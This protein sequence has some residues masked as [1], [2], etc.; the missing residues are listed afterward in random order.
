[1]DLSN[2]YQEVKSLPDDV[3]QR[4]MAQP[5]GMIPS[6]LIMG[7]LYD[8][9]A[10]RGS[11]NRQKPPTIAEQIRQSAQ[12]MPQPQPQPQPMPVQGFSRGG[13]VGMINPFNTFAQSLKNPDIQ[14]G[15]Q[16]EV[17]NQANGGLTPLLPLQPAQPTGEPYGLASLTPL[18][19]GQPAGIDSGGLATLLRSAK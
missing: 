11:M 4:E 6:Y 12:R 5:S 18:P 13:M 17:M 9:Q 14:A 16:Q 10:L 3:L 7:E 1:M 2:A 19:P 15:M 8:R